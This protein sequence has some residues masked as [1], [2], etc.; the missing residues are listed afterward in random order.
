MADKKIDP[1][2]YAPLVAGYK[3]QDKSGSTKEEDSEELSYLDIP[4]ASSGLQPPDGVRVVE[5]IFRKGADGRTVAD[6]VIEVDD[7][8]GVT[9]YE[10]R[11]SIV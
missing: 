11:T 1:R 10:V 3:Y 4:V 6:L 2:L 8:P 9:S 7:M 5:Q